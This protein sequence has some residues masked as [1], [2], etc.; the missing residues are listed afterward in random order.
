MTLGVP[1]VKGR[2]FDDSDSADARP[3]A[4]LSE[5]LARQ[6]FKGHD[7][8]GQRFESLTGGTKYTIIGVVA[9]TRNSAL[10]REPLPEVFTPYLQQPHSMTFLVRTTGDPG[11]LASA[12]R[13]AVFS[14]DKN[15]P[16][17]ELQTMNHV[18]AAAIAPRRFRML[19]V[20]LFALLALALATVGVYGVMMTSISQRT[21]EIGIRVALGAQRR[22]VMKLVLGQG[23]LLGVG[24]VAVGVC[25]AL[26]LMHYA[27]TQLFGVTPTDPLTFCCASIVL[28]IACLLAA[29]LP[30]RKVTK[31]DP[32]TALRY[33]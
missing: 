32:M 31:A 13:S 3:V 1:L 11:S 5:S 30:A 12:V 33:E 6:A 22:D 8:L 15:Q 16:I 21:H 28:I 14:I 17:S 26:W 25:A 20:G 24:G 4:M 7:P 10:D 27:S 19:L 2:F 29:Y 9:D 18:L 23:A